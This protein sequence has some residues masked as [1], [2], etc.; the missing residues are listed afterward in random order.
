MKRHLEIVIEVGDVTRDGCG[1]CPFRAFDW[2][3]GEPVGDEF[4]TCPAWPMQAAGVRHADC[5]AAE[6]RTSDGER[7][8]VR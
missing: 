5:L 2:N 8:R 7:D 4:C 1:E 3:G 6:R